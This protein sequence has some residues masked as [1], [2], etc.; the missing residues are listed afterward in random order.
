M[1]MLAK[2]LAMDFQI[3]HLDTLL[4]LDHLQSDLLERLDDLDQRV[5]CVLA[6]CNATRTVE[7]PVGVGP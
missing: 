3:R 5:A 7:V 1:K 6:E 2:E 4:E